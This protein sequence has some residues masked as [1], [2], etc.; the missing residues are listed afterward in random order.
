MS[1]LATLGSISGTARGPA[2]AGE[3]APIVSTAIASPVRN[4][5]MGTPYLR[6]AAARSAVPITSAAEKGFR[7][8]SKTLRRMHSQATS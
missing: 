6:V 1:A 5:G 8:T 4:R 2:K 7:K 3:A